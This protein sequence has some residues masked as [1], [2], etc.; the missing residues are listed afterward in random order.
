[1]NYSWLDGSLKRKRSSARRFLSLTRQ[2]SIQHAAENSL[3][4][5]SSR[6]MRSPL[7]KKYDT[8]P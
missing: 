3:V 5:E 4:D 1:M 8:D 6:V 7:R 2:A